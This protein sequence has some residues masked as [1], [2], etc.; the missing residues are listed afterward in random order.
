V[1]S[2]TT[3]TKIKPTATE[4]SSGT[5]VSSR[6]MSIQSVTPDK[7]ER[8]KPLNDVFQDQKEQVPFKERKSRKKQS[9]AGNDHLQKKA[10]KDAIHDTQKS[11]TIQRN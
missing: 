9:K 6:G 3:K 5:T 11:T 2:L 8:N 4:D 7:P 1:N 10:D